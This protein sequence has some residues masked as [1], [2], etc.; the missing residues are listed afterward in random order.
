MVAFA[1]WRSHR[2]MIDSE[3]LSVVLAVWGLYEMMLD[4]VIEM[5]LWHLFICTV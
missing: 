4:G 1:W 2:S 5:M 3:V